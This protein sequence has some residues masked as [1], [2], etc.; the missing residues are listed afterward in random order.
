[1]QFGEVEYHRMHTESKRERRRECQL[2][3]YRAEIHFK[4]SGAIESC[5]CWQCCSKHRSEEADGAE[6][7]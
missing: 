7:P 4:K 1:M 3:E 6:A 2:R 5:Q